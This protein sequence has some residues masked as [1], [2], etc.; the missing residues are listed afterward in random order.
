MLRLETIPLLICGVFCNVAAGQQHVPVVFTIDNTVSEVV[1][2]LAIPGSS[3]RDSSPVS[4]TLEAELDIDT[5]GGAANVTGIEFTGG[6]FTNDEPFNL[7]LTV[8][9][10]LMAD[11]EGT[12][13]VGSPSTPMPPGAVTRNLADPLRFQY[14]AADHV[15]T[16]HEGM[17]RADGAFEESVDLSEEPLSGAPPVGS[18][19]T[20][21]LTPR[22]MVGHLTEFDATLI[23]PTIFSDTFDVDAGLFDVPVTIDV[24]G[25]VLALGSFLLD[26]G[27]GGAAGPGDYNGNGLVEQADLDLVLSHWGED[28]TAVG[29]DWVSD[30]PQGIIDQGELDGVLANWGQSS[31]AGELTGA[32]TVPEPTAIALF[33]VCVCATGQWVR[34][35]RS[36]HRL[37]R[38]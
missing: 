8:L 6:E 25:Q 10:F 21:E 23:Q 34:R 9:R 36:R 17:L 27:G 16:L 4:G 24:S 20:I 18:F 33:L 3:D 30:P 26:L 7:S 13:L 11:L 38:S 35:S 12:D 1:I 28:A 14:D 5:F 22:G 15:L 31:S 32:T 19:A 37:Q 2:D 29:E